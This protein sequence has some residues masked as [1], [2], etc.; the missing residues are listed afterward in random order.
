MLL[1][2][3]QDVINLQPSA[4]VILAGINDIAGNTGPSTIEMIADNIKSMAELAHANNIKVILC[5]VLPA[6]DFPWRPGMEPAEKVLKLNAIIHTYAKEQGFTYIDYFSAV[7]NEFNGL[8]IDLG[9]D[10]VHPN[11]KGYAIMEPLLEEAIRE[12][13]N[14]N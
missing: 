12:A 11:A 7:S 5:S 6:G 1:R 13:L 2:F 8:R 4:V 14:N 3:R 9:E 10:G